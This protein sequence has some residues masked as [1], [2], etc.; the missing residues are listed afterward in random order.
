MH[1][2]SVTVSA[3]LLVNK[4]IEHVNLWGGGIAV[5]SANSSFCSEKNSENNN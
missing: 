4:F 2:R 1:I 5:S 3:C